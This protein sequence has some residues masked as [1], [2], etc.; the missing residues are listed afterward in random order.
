MIITTINVLGFMAGVIYTYY[1]GERKRISNYILIFSVIM[2]ILMAFLLGLYADGINEL[3]ISLPLTMYSLMKWNENEG[4]KKVAP[5][6]ASVLTHV[7]AVTL[8]LII[9]IALGFTIGRY[10][11][12]LPVINTLIVSVN[13]L[14]YYYHAN[15]YK[16]G[17]LLNILV[18]GLYVYQYFILWG[19]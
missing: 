11:T 17:W 19:N 6:K 9:W 7:K 1:S 5:K 13:I 10:Q 3:L 16:E 15:I 4:D 14:Y 2:N 8:G 12:V 18:C